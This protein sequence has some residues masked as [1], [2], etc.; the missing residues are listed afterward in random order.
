MRIF[1]FGLL[2]LAA[3]VLGSCSYVESDTPPPLS[4]TKYQPIILDVGSIEFVDEYKSPMQDPY[5]EHRLPYSPAEAMHI[6]VKD[7][8]R[9]NGNE[10]T[11][12][13]IIKDARVV[14]STLPNSSGFLSM[15]G[16]GDNKRYDLSLVVEM[17]IY[18]RDSAMSLASLQVS[19]T[20]NITINERTSAHERE[21]MFRNMVADS[22]E[23][24]NAELEKNIFTY[25]GSNITYQ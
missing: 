13:V 25:F 4:F 12:Q 19:T 6:W 23:V 2:I 11:L 20:R 24:M 18:G 9:A 21:V 22:M 7:R 5:V 3:A 14:V 1:K 10:K 16:I 17:R 8:I 15:M